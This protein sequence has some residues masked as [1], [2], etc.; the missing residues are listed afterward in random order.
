MADFVRVPEADWRDIC[1]SVREKTGGEDGLLSG[2]VA[3]AVRGIQSGGETW[4]NT[5]GQLYTKNIF[6]E[7]TTYLPAYA[8]QN[9]VYLE[10]AI[11]PNCAKFGGSWVLGDNPVLKIVKL[12]KVYTVPSSTCRNSPLLEELELGSIGYPISS[13]ISTS[14][15]NPTA[16]FTVTVYVDAATLAD[17][18]TAVS[19]TAPWGAP[20]ATIIYRNSTTGEVITE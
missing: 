11:F 9:C 1:D 16:T 17:I 19:D 2:E 20:N 12:G 14:L 13:M 4:F 5:R 3:P 10:S 8:Y 18:P 7:E 15:F 6:S